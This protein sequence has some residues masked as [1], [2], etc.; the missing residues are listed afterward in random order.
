[1]RWCCALSHLVVVRGRSV[2]A[3][4]GLLLA[5]NLGVQKYVVTRGQAQFMVRARQTKTKEPRMW[6]W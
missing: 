4:D 6:E 2:R 5:L 3:H 1:M